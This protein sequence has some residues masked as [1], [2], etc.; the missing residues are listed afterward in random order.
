MGRV[1]NITY[2]P[3]NKTVQVDMD[4]IPTT[5]H[6]EPASLLDIALANGIAI[7]HAC[8]GVCAC[9][10][11]HI[12]VKKGAE[13]LTPVDDATRGNDMLDQAPELSL[14]SR[15]ACQA[16]ITGGGDVVVE[17]PGWNRNLVRE[18]H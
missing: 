5:G 9:S 2:L 7:D 13:H 15:L 6:G 1:V 8:G 3:M 17:V 12:H 10:T 18:G 4:A 11:C 14:E 16:Q